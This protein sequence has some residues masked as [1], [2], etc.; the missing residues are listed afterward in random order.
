MRYSFFIFV[1][2]VLLSSNGTA[3]FNDT[4]H[5]D[6]FGQTPPG[7]TAVVF[8][9]DF[10]SKPGVF[11][12]NCCFSSDGKEFV[13]GLT[14]NQWS[15]A[16][17]MYTK[18]SNGVWST[19]V[20]INEAG[21]GGFTPYFSYDN[22]DLYYAAGNNSSNSGDIFV[23]HRTSDGWSGPDTLGSPIN[24][25]QNEWEL[26]LPS[27]NVMYFSSARTGGYGDM[28]IYR[29]ELVNGSWTNVTNLG[30]P[31]NTSSK[32][33]C[34]YVAP[35]ESFMVFNDWKYNPHFKGNNLYITYRKSDG[36]W[37]NPKG[38]GADINSDQLDIYP[39]ITPDG[40]YLIFTRRD[41]AS[42]AKYSQLY[43]ART[44]F[45]DSL[46]HTN[47]DPYCKNPIPN[48]TATVGVPFTYTIPDSIFCDD[49]INDTLTYSIG[50]L[51]T[52]LS[53]DDKTKTFSGTPTAKANAR[54]CVVTI[55]DPSNS[56][57]AVYFSITVQNAND[58][59]DNQSSVLE[60]K[61]N[62]N[63][64]NPFNPSTTIT[65]ELKSTT[66]VD[67]TIFDLLGR[68]IRT[69]LHG[70]ESAGNHQLQWDGTDE[71]GKKAASGI[72]FCR[73]NA[74]HFSD[75]QKMILLQ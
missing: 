17:L 73:M 29:A 35:D 41:A 65:Y 27:K 18:F 63:F 42:P 60:Y 6:Y 64:P 10:I 50:G 75:V 1:I 71:R 15:Y 46:R 36:S 11:V 52:W 57:A 9:P 51:P 20:K 25:K 38:L 5:I 34:P 39:Y 47:F 45:V 74:E 22:N 40:K 19:P 28:D 54:W 8:S 69:L 21:N 70:Q 14:D 58:V 13:Y 72:Y 61:L 43:W 37:T 2:V 33:E 12:E 56:K 26:C 48:L 30:I 49:D 66:E 32:D 59:N 62:Q 7:K 68:K 55:T 4:L 24:S 31:I 16:Y 23:L 67:I 53:Y 3:Q 44:N